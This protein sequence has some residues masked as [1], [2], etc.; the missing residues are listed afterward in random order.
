[1]PFWHYLFAIIFFAGSVFVMIFYSSKKQRIYKVIAGII[2]V[3]AMLGTFLF[4]W[5]SLLI[6]EWIGLLPI[7]VHFIGETLNKID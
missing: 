6:A 4:N 5:Y 7:C 3:L 1:Y 2:V